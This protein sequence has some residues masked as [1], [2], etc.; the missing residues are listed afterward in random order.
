ALV[1][2]EPLQAWKDYLRFRAIDRSASL[3]PRAYADLHFDFHGKALQ[4]TP[5]QRERWKR[6]VAATSQA[7]GDAV[8]QLYAKRYFPPASKAQVEEMV[9][10]IL[11]AFREGVDKLEWMTPETRATAKA[12]AEAMRVSVGY[13]DA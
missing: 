13:P 6:A 9:H 3:L 2:S 12:K 10:N 4:G 1:A 8:G 5:K 11:A 7:L